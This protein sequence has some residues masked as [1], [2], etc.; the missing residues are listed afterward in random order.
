MNEKIEKLEIK[1]SYLEDENATLNE[2]VTDLNKRVGILTSELE[3]IKK[4]VRDILENEGEERE[5][6]RPPHY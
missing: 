5:N 1:V 4:K 6:R 3:E 2:V